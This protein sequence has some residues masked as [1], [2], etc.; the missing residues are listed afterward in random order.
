MGPTREACVVGMQQPGTAITQGSYITITD[1]P[2]EHEWETSHVAA[3]TEDRTV[4][5]CTD[6]CVRAC[7]PACLSVACLPA[8]LPVW[9]ACQE[10]QPAASS[11]GGVEWVEVSTWLR[12][13]GVGGGQHVAE[14][15]VGRGQHVAKGVVKWVEVST[16]LRYTVIHKPR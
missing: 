5:E 3:N 8:C 15:G 12:V 10:T 13:G 9:P 6:V 1:C 2:A 14:S 11:E 7:L 16:W 4:A